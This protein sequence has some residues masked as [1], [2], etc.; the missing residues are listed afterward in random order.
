MPDNV[1][2]T[3]HP[4]PRLPGGNG[5]A[6]E[7]GTPSRE[8]LE[9]ANRIVR[10]S[11]ARGRTLGIKRPGVLERLRLYEIVG[12]QNTE[13]RKYLGLAGAAFC[14]VELDGE[15]LAL[16]ATRRELE[17]RL[18]L[19]GEEGVDAINRALEKQRQEPGGDAT[20]ETLK[21]VP[22]TLP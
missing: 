1:K 16:P 17:A 13:N 10:V 7:P 11:D 19:L 3:L 15:A 4:D 22:G 9:R 12:P 8:I 2:L 18:I 21:N 6:P 20:E 14:A 5:A